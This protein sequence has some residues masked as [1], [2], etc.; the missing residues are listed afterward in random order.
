[1]RLNREQH[2][3]TDKL[4]VFPN[5]AKRS[6]LTKIEKI[7]V[8]NKWRAEWWEGGRERHDLFSKLL[9]CIPLFPSRFSL[10]T[11]YNCYGDT[12]ELLKLHLWQLLKQCAVCG[13]IECY[14]RLLMETVQRKINIPQRLCGSHTKNIVLSTHSALSLKHDIQ[15][16]CITWLMH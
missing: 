3:S 14:L 10:H 8:P 6:A 16:Y 4:A 2:S 11:H 5:Q 13:T 7:C 15:I 1:M 12:K 9:W